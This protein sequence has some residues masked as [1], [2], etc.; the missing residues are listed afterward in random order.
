MNIH[1]THPPP[2]LSHLFCHLLSLS[3]FQVEGEI[4][5]DLDGTYF[6]N[7]PGLQVRG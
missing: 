4:P 1:L 6:R 5:K 7:G 2:H 3:S